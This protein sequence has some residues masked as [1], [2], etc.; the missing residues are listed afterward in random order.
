[1]SKL[2]RILL[3]GL[4]VIVVLAV[5]GITF[6]VGWRPFIGPRMRAVTSR[7]FERTPERLTR[8]QYIFA[9]HACLDCHG[10]H[11]P[12]NPEGFLFDAQPAGEVMPIEG[13]PGRV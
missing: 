3:Y 4:L 1:M 9:S 5:L 6:T 10:Q 2:G 7:T 11:D 12:K 8:G 13:L